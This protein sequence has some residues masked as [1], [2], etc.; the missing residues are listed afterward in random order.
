MARRLLAL[1]GSLV[2]VSV[3]LEVATRV[4]IGH[5][6]SIDQ[7]KRYASLA[8]VEERLAD[9][10]SES[11]DPRATAFVRH[12]YLG[13]IARPGW[14][15]GP[16]RHNARGFRGAEITVPKPAGELRIAC[17]GGSSTYT[18]AVADWHRSYPAQLEEI[19]HARGHPEVTVVNAGLHGWTTWETLINFELRLLELEPDVIVVYH[20]FN[21]IKPRFVWPPERYRADNSGYRAAPASVFLPPLW[22]HSALM[23]VVMTRLGRMTPQA[24]LERTLD[25]QTPFAHWSEFRAQVRSGTYPRRFFAR[26]GADRILDANPPIWFERNLESLVRLARA[27]G[28][29]VVLSTVALRPEGLAGGNPGT[30]FLVRAMDEMN[31]AVAEVAQRTDALLFDFAAGFPRDEALFADHVHVTAEG[32]AEKARRFADFLEA[33]VLR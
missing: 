25:E 13:F 33:R 19:L 30:E 14:R 22:E 29:T 1:S 12:R 28:I 26:V 17:L 31:A 10:Q 15:S 27:E 23:R 8:Q 5:F 6:A 32:A 24:E 2:A 9:P 21:D 3:L 16:N 20:G 7:F 4:W 11:E 18:S